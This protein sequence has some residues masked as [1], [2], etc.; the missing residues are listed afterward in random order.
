MMFTGFSVCLRG[1]APL[2]GRRDLSAYKIHDGMC[3]A[4]SMHGLQIYAVHYQLR[5]STPPGCP[6]H[7]PF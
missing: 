5:T 7:D 4:I 1:P 6:V 3:P 2:A